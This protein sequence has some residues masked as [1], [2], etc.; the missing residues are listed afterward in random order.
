MNLS[1]ERYRDIVFRQDKSTIEKYF[2]RLNRRSA[3]YDDDVRA[4]DRQIETESSRRLAGWKADLQNFAVNNSQD[5]Y[6]FGMA[7]FI[8]AEFLP[9]DRLGLALGIT[10]LPP[11]VNQANRL[12]PKGLFSRVSDKGLY[13]GERVFVGQEVSHLFGQAGAVI[14]GKTIRTVPTDVSARF[15][16]MGYL[17]PMTN[18]FKSAPI[19]QTLEVDHIFP[20]KEIMRLPRFKK[21]TTEQQISII[22]DRVDIGNFQ[23]LPKTFN[24]SKGSK[25]DW[26]TYRQNDVNPAYERDLI[27]RQIE[28]E[29]SI[30]R[31]INLFYKA[32]RGAK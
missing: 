30:Q 9:T 10:P 19:N 17:D 23:P 6:Y 4:F 25:L 12:I 16:G 22:H 29:N 2:Q 27:N 7:G 24:A 32:N 31:Q 28:I 18:T 1:L 21:L 15:Q 20:V 14:N 11:L 26:A 5:H 3:Q 8:A 13:L